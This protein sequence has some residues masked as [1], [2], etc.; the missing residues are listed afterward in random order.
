MP[1]KVTKKTTKVLYTTGTIDD[2]EI[3]ELW[4]DYYGGKDKFKTNPFAKKYKEELKPQ[5]QRL[6]DSGF[7]NEIMNDMIAEAE[8][9]KSWKRGP[10]SE[11]VNLTYLFL[12]VII[13]FSVCAVV[14]TPILI[15]AI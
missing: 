14:M 11:T 6:E 13:G 8:Q 2:K 15:N 12:G 9:I 5:W 4:K 1:K 10:I 7:Y 3:N